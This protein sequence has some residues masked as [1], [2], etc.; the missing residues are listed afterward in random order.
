MKEGY[1]TPPAGARDGD[2]SG[3]LSRVSHSYR[4]NLQRLL[5]LVSEREKQGKSDSRFTLHIYSP[6]VMP[7]A[8]GRE[9]AERKTNNR[10]STSFP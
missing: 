1:H 6:N 2:V 5:I 4:H 7:F 10:F 3:S 9:S 8:A